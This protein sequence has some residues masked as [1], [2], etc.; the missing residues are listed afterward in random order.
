M[1]KT[2]IV[3]YGWTQ[4]AERL[5]ALINRDGTGKPK[6]IDLVFRD[7]ATVHGV[8]VDWLKKFYTAGNYFAWDWLRDPLA[9]GS[10]F[11]CLFAGGS[12]DSNGYFRRVC[13]LWSG[14]V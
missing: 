10:S 11:L 6:L 12:F 2:L 4:D 14:C 8:T 3:S 9:I 13:I 1:S 5:G 7:L